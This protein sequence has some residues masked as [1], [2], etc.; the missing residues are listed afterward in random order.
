MQGF[1]KKWFRCNGQPIQMEEEKSFQK[2][3][4]VMGDLLMWKKIK[5]LEGTHYSRDK[6]SQNYTFYHFIPSPFI[7]S[8]GQSLVKVC[9]IYT[10]FFC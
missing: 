10:H 6:S 8:I 1:F 7:I 9:S 2:A 4:I 3:L 5:R